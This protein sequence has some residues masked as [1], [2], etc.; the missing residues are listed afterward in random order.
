MAVCLVLVPRLW[1]FAGSVQPFV[2]VVPPHCRAGLR[3]SLRLI[4]SVSVLGSSCWFCGSSGSSCSGSRLS[5][6]RPLRF[7]LV[8]PVQ[9]RLLRLLAFSFGYRLRCLWLRV[10]YH[11]GSTMPFWFLVLVRVW[12][13]RFMPLLRFVHAAVRLF[14]AV[15]FGLVY[16]AAGCH[17]FGF[18]SPRFRVLVGSAEAVYTATGIRFTCRT[19]QHGLVRDGSAAGSVVV[20]QALPLYRAFSCSGS[21]TGCVPCFVTFSPP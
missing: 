8:L 11:F 16:L 1:F 2:A 9:W 20:L 7:L 4:R 13:M 6:F 17:Y 19:R 10:D 21:V 18:A 15:W 5:M 14:V 12:F 3:C